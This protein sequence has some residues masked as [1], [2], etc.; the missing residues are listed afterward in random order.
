MGYT[1]VT[2]MD[3]H[4]YRFTEWADF[5]TEG[6]DKKVNW[7]RN[8]GKELYNHSSDAG[9][10]FNLMVTQASDPTTTALAVQLSKALHAGPDAARLR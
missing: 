9:E 4:E 5:N 3:G 10:N 8:V 6:F 1:M 7:A 2:R